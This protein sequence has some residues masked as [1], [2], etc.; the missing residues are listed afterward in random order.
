MEI[1][2]GLVTDFTGR[3][4]RLKT[5]NLTVGPGLREFSRRLELSMGLIQFW[6]AQILKSE[7]PKI[8]LNIDN[9]NRMLKG[10]KEDREVALTLLSSQSIYIHRILRYNNDPWILMDIIEEY[11]RN[12]LNELSLEAL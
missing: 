4:L 6:A 12:N 10:S 3:D 2:T 7:L 9:I 5:E 11:T 8:S 1:V